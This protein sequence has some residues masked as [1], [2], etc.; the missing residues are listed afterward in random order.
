VKLRYFAGLTSAEAADA[1][2]ISPSA[3]KRLWSY[4]RAWLRGAMRAAGHPPGR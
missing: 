2:D 4:A 1:L 3:A